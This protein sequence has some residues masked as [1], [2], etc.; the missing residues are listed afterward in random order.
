MAQRDGELALGR[1]PAAYARD[2]AIVFIG[3]VRSPWQS[4]EEC[5]KNMAAAREAGK[6]ATIEVEPEF[7]QGLLGLDGYSH[8]VLLS[9][10]DRAERNLIVQK[11]RHATEA[12]GVFALRSPVRPNPIGLHIVELE[13]LDIDAGRLSIDAID[14]LDGTPILDIKPYFASTD[15][16][17]DAARPPR[18]AT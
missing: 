14:L 16:F 5:P 9:W 12:K 6:Q 4:R 15:A 8:V 13:A 2:G 3:R 7:R 1:D 10:F 18:P 11:P 17:A